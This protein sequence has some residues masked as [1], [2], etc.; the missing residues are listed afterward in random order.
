MDKG[1]LTVCIKRV[2][3]AAFNCNQRAYEISSV[4]LYIINQLGDEYN[5]LCCVKNFVILMN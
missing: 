5:S 1:R 4:A 3:F 2:P